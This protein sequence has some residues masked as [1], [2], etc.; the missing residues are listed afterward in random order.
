METINGIKIPI[1]E[2]SLSVDTDTDYFKT[3]CPP[4]KMYLNDI[5]SIWKH[6]DKYPEMSMGSGTNYNENVFDQLKAKGIISVDINKRVY[7]SKINKLMEIQPIIP[8]AMFSYK[9]PEEL[10]RIQNFYM[11][12]LENPYIGIFWGQNTDNP[13]N[14][15]RIIELDWLPVPNRKM[16]YSIN[17]YHYNSMS[18]LVLFHHDPITKTIRYLQELPIGN[19]SYFFNKEEDFSAQRLLEL[20]EIL[21]NK[22]IMD[23]INGWNFFFVSRYKYFFGESP[24]KENVLDFKDDFDL[25]NQNV[26]FEELTNQDK[27][28]LF[29]VWLNRLHEFVSEVKILHTS[30]HTVVLTDTH[31]EMNQEYVS[32]NTTYTPE[33]RKEILS[34]KEKLKLYAIAN[35]W[36]ISN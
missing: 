15:M 12:K 6:Y 36:F 4:T 35:D 11:Q 17:I 8:E 2:F 5:E 1:Y 25:P 32:Y 34:K 30:G 7:D 26:K 13:E 27:I 29:L 22:K 28:K 20:E 31:N 24:Y 16:E 14:E 23:L 19:T 33:I 3:V 18:Y 10:E 21:P 9:K